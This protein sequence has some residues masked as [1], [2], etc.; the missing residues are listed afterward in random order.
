[1]SYTTTYTEY[2]LAR[3]FTL[4]EQQNYVRRRLG[5]HVTSR[6]RRRVFSL[7]RHGETT[8]TPR[9]E[10]GLSQGEVHVGRE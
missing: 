9:S 1:M 8:S 4:G 3:E 6:V 10:D 2:V 7:S 5:D